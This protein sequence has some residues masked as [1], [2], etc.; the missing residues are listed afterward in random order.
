MKAKPKM[1]STGASGERFLGGATAWG[2]CGCAAGLKGN[3]PFGLPHFG[4][5]GAAS[6]IC[7]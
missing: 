7:E 3:T 5:A 1:I 4:Q 2:G 6:L